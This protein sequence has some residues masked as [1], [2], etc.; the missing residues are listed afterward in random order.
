MRRKEVNDIPTPAVTVCVSTRNRSSLLPQLAGYLERQTIGVDRFEVVVVDNGSTDDTW[1]MLQQ[2]QQRSPLNLRIHQNPP[3]KGP[4]AGRNRAWRDA[5]APL[6]AFTDDDCM[7][8]G[9]WLE[10]ALEGLAGRRAA[11]AGRVFWPPS[12]EPL[13]GPF[14]RTVI[15]VD[16][17]A[18]W[19]ATA[20]LVVR[21]DDLEAVGGFD[22]GFLNVAG[23]DTDLLFRILDL[24]AEFV[25]LNDALVHHGVEQVGF[26]GLLRDQHR[27]VDIPAVIARNPRARK[28]LL[29]RGV[30]WKPTHSR[31]LLALTA[32]AALP[33]TPAAALLAA[34]W[35]HHR[36]CHE[37]LAESVAERVVTLPAAFVLDL[38]EVWTMI[39]GS[40]RHRT[41]VL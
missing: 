21:R 24:G 38:A 40:V 26:R 22:E 5:A 6:C 2:L 25:F 9:D 18:K 41:F 10:K 20:N 16:G 39:R 32:L 7:P 27:W 14:T 23:E 31:A 30:F 13:V 15:A 8:T 35:L 33:A 17:H 36:T 1:K 11:A 34:P 37:P 3:G 12:Q 19:G 29:H 4:A 28:E